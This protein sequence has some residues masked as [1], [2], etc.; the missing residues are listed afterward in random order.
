MVKASQ[1]D[2]KELVSA[3][4]YGFIKSNQ[5]NKTSKTNKTAKIN[6]AN[7]SNKNY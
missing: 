2:L 3:K 7:K 5:N 1:A 4:F 6:E